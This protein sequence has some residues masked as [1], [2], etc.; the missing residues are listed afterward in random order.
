Q[1]E[2]RRRRRRGEGEGRGPAHRRQ[3]VPRQPYGVQWGPGR[4]GRDQLGPGY[5][6]A[7]QPPRGQLGRLRWGRLGIQRRPSHHRRQRDPRQHCRCFCG[8][9]APRG[10]R[11]LQR[12]RSAGL[13]A[14]GERG[15]RTARSQRRRVRRLRLPGAVLLPQ[16]HLLGGPVAHRGMWGGR[17]RVRPPLR[18]PGCRRLPPQPRVTGDRRRRQR[19][20]ATAGDGPG[21]EPAGRRRERRRHGQ[22]RHGRLRGPAPRARAG[23]RRRVPSPRPGPHPRYP[24]RQ[25]R[26][27]RPARPRGDPQPPGDRSGRCAGDGRDGGRPQCHCDRADRHQLPDRLAGGGGH[28]ACVQPELHRRPDRAEPRR[29]EGGYGRAGPSVQQRRDGPRHRRRRRLVRLRRCPRRRGPLLASRSVPHPR[30]P[31]RGGRADRSGRPGIQSCL[32]GHR[33]GRRAAHRGVG[34]GAERH[35]DRAHADELHHCLAHAPAAA[36]GLQPQR[37]PRPDGAQPGGRQGGRRWHGQPL[38]Q[39]GVGP[40]RGRRGRMVR[41]GPRGGGRVHERRAGPSPRHPGH[42]GR[43]GGTGVGHRPAGDWAGRRSGLRRF[44][45]RAQRD[46]HRGHGQQPPDRLAERRLP[47]ARLQPQLCR[48]QHGAQP[49]DRQGWGGW[50]GQPLQQRRMDPCDRRRGR[51]VLRM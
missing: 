20:C 33:P 21:R 48:R 49:R 10:E 5:R 11:H 4:G 34:C 9:C 12:Q 45:G 46:R 26:S 7:R 27:A 40:P 16:Q 41:R 23:C 24:D 28:A 38:Q 36:A 18:R 13:V 1:R 2:R 35:C 43:Q 3:R 6:I 8:R 22:G 25:R 30:H 44:C 50:S 15:H 39:R 42:R 14:G 31:L 47:A 19:L 37:H 51:L 17:D 32:A 29:R